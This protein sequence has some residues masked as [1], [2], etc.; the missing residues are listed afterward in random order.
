MGVQEHGFIMDGV[1]TI[2]GLLDR[3]VY[4]LIKWILFGIFDLANLTTNSDVFSGIYSRIYVILGIFMAFKLSFSFFQYIIDPESMTGKSDK[5]ISKLFIRVMIMLSALI[6]LPTL[7][8]G[9]NGNEGL[10]TRAQNAFLPSV[11]KFIFGVDDLGG[12]TVGGNTDSE[13]FSNSIEQSANDIMI[14][15]LSGFF[16]PSDDLDEACG[17]GTYDDT[18]PIENL[19]DF[20]NDLLITCNKKGDIV[21]GTTHFHTGTKFYKYSYMWFISTVVG[22]LIAALL[23]GI[24]LDIAK[25]IFKLMV[26][27]VIAPIPIMS[28]IDPKGSKD[29]AFSKWWHSLLSTFLDIFI[30]L[31]LVYI[32]IVMI[33]LIV[34]AVNGGN[35]FANFPQ[36]SG[37]RGTYLTILLI[38]GLIFFAKEAPKFIKNA[39]GIKSEGGGL[40]DD[41]KSI[42]KAAGLVGGAAVGTAGVIGSGLTNWRAAK[43][44]NAELHEG[45]GVRNFFRNSA[46]AVAGAIGGAAVGAK[47]LTGKNAGIKSVMDAQGKRNAQRAAHSTAF[48]RLGS[49]VYG[50]FTGR[51]LSEKGNAELKYNQ[52]AFKNFKEYKSTLETEALKKTDLVGTL[53]K[54]VYAGKSF[55]YE[56]LSAALERARGSGAS[57]FSYNGEMFNTDEFDV[58]TMNDI[59]SSQAASYADLLMR[60]DVVVDASGNPKLDSNGRAVHYQDENGTAYNAY[61]SAAA[62]ARNATNKTFDGSY[63]ST[64]KAMGEVKTAS[65]KSETSM[66]YQKRRAND[67]AKK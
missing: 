23:L 30:K 56:K 36:N 13:K 24:T 11:P 15:T 58:N 57:Q 42:G 29:G 44:E 62:A 17:D 14:T 37:F 3:L 59:K 21:I 20:A 49:N 67:R 18:P 47:A 38:L 46:S 35:L 33:H 27:E 63:K 2:F 32:I 25:R 19:E 55:N 52:E 9:Q 45:Q 43:E 5:S 26:L 64:K 16:A 7:L 39:L 22:I 66:K 4:G 65:T 12:L 41:V 8:F 6:L 28:L 40:F 10:L 34:Q 51:G 31:G 54:G 1:R 61:L 50:A 53:D 48:G 60:N